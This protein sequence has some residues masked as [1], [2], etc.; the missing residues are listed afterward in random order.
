MVYKRKDEIIQEEET[1]TTKKDSKETR[2][3]SQGRAKSRGN[4]RL[5]KDEEEKEP[6]QFTSAYEEFRA[7]YWRRPKKERVYVTLETVIPP[8]PKNP[9]E[10]PDETMY[11]KQQAEF[12]EKID[13]IN[14]KIKDL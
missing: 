2:A 3:K 7:G 6:P 5:Q 8:L 13:A 1:Q 14:L 12:D 9:L 11:H 10:Y 4:N